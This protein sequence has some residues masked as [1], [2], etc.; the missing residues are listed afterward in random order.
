[1]LRSYADVC[2]AAFV[3]EIG[4][5]FLAKTGGDPQEQLLSFLTKSLQLGSQI[6]STVAKVGTFKLMAVSTPTL[7]C[8]ECF[9]NF[10]SAC[11]AQH[12]LRVY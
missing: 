9:S 4:L 7:L 6:S 10:A 5:R 12:L 1:M 8:Q 11:F 2:D 3:L